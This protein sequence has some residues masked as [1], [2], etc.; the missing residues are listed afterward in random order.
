MDGKTREQQVTENDTAGANNSMNNNLPKNEELRRGEKIERLEG[1]TRAQIERME[2]IQVSN[3]SQFSQLNSV[4][5]QI[6]QRLQSIPGSSHGSTNS[7]K[8]PPK[9]S[10]QVR[11][12]KLDFPRFDGKN[13]MDWIFKAEQ[14]FDYYST[15]DADRL[16]TTS[17]NLDH[18]VVPWYQMM[19]KT[20]PMLSWPALT[21]ALELDFG[22][23]AYE[24]PR[25]TLFKLTQAASVNDFYMQFTALV[26]RVDGLSPDAILDCFISGLQEEIRR[27][28]KAM[29]PKILSKAFAL[30]KLYEEKYS[31]NKPKPFTSHARNYNQ[32]NTTTNKNPQT[33]QITD[34]T[35]NNLPPLLPTP[36]SKPLYQ[37]NQNI[38]KISPA[39]I[40]L[41]REKN[42]CYFC[43]EK[44]S[45]SH[46]CPNRQVM[47]LQL[48]D[49]EEIQ[50]D[51]TAGVLLEEAIINEHHH[52]SLN[53]MRGA[54]GIGTIRFTGQ[55]GSISVKILVDG[56]SSD[57]FIQ[58]RVAQVLKFP[59]EPATNL[60]VLVGNG[61]VLNA[62]GKI[63]QLLVQIQGQEIKIPV[64]LLQTSGAD[65]ILGSTWLATLGPHVAD[66]AALT[67]KFFRQGKFITL[68]GETNMEPSPAQL[69]QFRR[70]H[71]T[72]AIEECFAVQL[73]NKEL[74]E[75][76][77]SELPS[78]IDPEIAMLLHTY[79]DVFKVPSTLP[80]P[81]EHDH[82]IPLQ[83]GSGP[84]KVRP[85]RYPYT[86]KE[87]IE[88]MVHEMLQQGI[89]QPIN[90]PYSS[91]ILL[92][93]KKDGSWRFGT[94]YR[95]L[96]TITVKD[97][98]PMPTVDELLDEL[99]GAQ[100]FSKLDLRSEY[101]QI[102]VKSED[103][104][105]R[106]L[107]GHTMVIMSG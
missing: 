27:D 74:P 68:Q 26:N 70:L 28:V 66:Y 92:V 39:E 29:E 7:Y 97:S 15:P 4:M 2:A 54:N 3:E 22:P 45:P 78:A 38:K 98:F 8:E 16:I 102:M 100:F 56:G 53:A 21:R 81:R 12:V 82:A 93:K 59:I 51:Q 11:S 57:N 10:F 34:T 36:Q 63:Q 25:A 46:K 65:I 41:R 30:A 19:Q 86:Q 64:Y 101:H 44:F 77:L 61:Q 69:H 105:L 58:P 9:N 37:K 13:V 14:F 76:I 95:A 103:R 94:D 87:Q 104:E 42:L 1:S 73:I 33:S 18:E 91:P 23:S 47:L 80:P 75:D 88:K 107:S 52:L 24:C 84:V 79:A 83:P 62:E 43:D 60:R 85:Y 106:Q 49:E 20:D 5:A 96:N 35:K 71:Y 67:L 72:D 31:T 17:V 55:V 50:S 32:N 6:L 99:Y 89:I 48:E 40:Q 90:S